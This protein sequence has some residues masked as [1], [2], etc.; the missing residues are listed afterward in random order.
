MKKI[1]LLLLGSIGA[2]SQT[3]DPSFGVNGVAHRT[4]SN[5][6]LNN[7][8]NDGLLQ[9]DG[10]IIYSGQSTNPGV[11][12]TNFLARYNTDGSPDLSFNGSGFKKNINP[13]R[14]IALQNDGKIVT[15]GDYYITRYLPNGNL[16]TSFNSTGRLLILSTDGIYTFLCKYISIQN[17]G[18]ILVSGTFRTG[19]NRLL[20]G[21]VRI[22]SNGTLDT[23]FGTNGVV[24]T[25]VTYYDSNAYSHKVQPNGKI[26]VFGEAYSGADYDFALIRLNTD[27]TLDSTFG[28]N[29]KAITPFDSGNDY[30]RSGELLPDGKL[31]LFGSASGKFA[32]ARYTSSGALDTSFGVNGKLVLNHDLQFDVNSM[33]T[34]GPKMKLLANGMLL[35][36][37]TSNNDYK[38]MQLFNDGFYDTSFG[39]NGFVTFDQGNDEATVL[40]EK[41]DGNIVI[42]GSSNTVGIMDSKLKQIEMNANGTNSVISNKTLDASI[43]YDRNVVSVVNISDGSIFT[44]SKSNINNSGKS[45]LSK[46]FA[47]GNPDMTFGTNGYIE[48]GNSSIM[49]GDNYNNNNRMI[50]LPDATILIASDYSKLYKVNL[51]GT[52]A[53]TFGNNGTLDLAG[54]YSGISYIDRFIVS[55]DNKILVITDYILPNNSGQAAVLKLNLN[56][57]LDTTFGTNGKVNYGFGTT[58]QS[59]DE[60][61][62]AI[63]Q[64]ISGKITI[65]SSSRE[66]L[67]GINTKVCFARLNPNGTFDTTFGTNGKFIYEYPYDTH[68]VGGLFFTPTNDLLVPLLFGANPQQN[69]QGT[70]KVNANGTLA[71]T[72][73]TNGVLYDNAGH[74]MIVRSDG[75]FLKAGNTSTSYRIVQYNPDGS[76]DTTFGVN[77]VLMH[78]A[79][80]TDLE[81]FMV[82]YAI[83]P[84]DKLL[85]SGYSS[86]GQQ[87]QILLVKYTNLNLG[88]VDLSEK[89][90]TALVYP[91]PIVSE[92]KL[93]YSLNST[94]TISVTLYDL[95]G[96]TVQQIVKNQEQQPGKHTIDFSLDQNSSAGN[97]FLV[98]SSEKGKQTI[99]ILKK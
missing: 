77:G 4:I 15:G 23:T 20:F 51:N 13:N 48:V 33:Q 94:E 28:N 89:Q 93:E 60:W 10:K 22:N 85:V 32:L 58:S 36:S 59:L 90:N 71:T 38:V 12:T 63:V 62:N 31:L 30:G 84:D 72:F 98:L 26:V 5:S 49:N 34:R 76:V 2:F 9:P 66:Q 21:V 16:D 61:P 78:P 80:T 11:N 87:T 39:Q 35:L 83:L 19:S 37:G 69:A 7:V 27:G 91:N 41:P 42:A 79:G 81:A 1:L 96:R 50:L 95:Q 45:I 52:F 55:N 8:L 14:I 17:D 74:Y 92:A 86:N 99:Q 3:L 47:N 75:K 57:T 18:K 65:T 54:Y 88:L 43:S 40:L 53:T 70:L 64:D 6:E 46:S 73:G 82:S 29:G 67:S 97:Y 68:L 25:A 44:L 56:G 24:R